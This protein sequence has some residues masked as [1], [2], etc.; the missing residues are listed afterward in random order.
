MCGHNI[1]SDFLHTWSIPLVRKQIRSEVGMLLIQRDGCSLLELTVGTRRGV[2][3][4]SQE[5]LK[6]I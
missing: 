4:V 1:Y 6:A 2:T 5:N 3:F